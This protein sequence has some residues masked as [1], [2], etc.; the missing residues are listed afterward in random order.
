MISFDPPTD[1]SLPAEGAWDVVRWATAAAY[2]KLLNDANRQAID[3][4][5]PMDGSWR[6]EVEAET[7]QRS[8]GSTW[9]HLRGAWREV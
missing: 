9:F 3:H 7:E 1:G 4:N 2:D 6:F 5:L 8:D